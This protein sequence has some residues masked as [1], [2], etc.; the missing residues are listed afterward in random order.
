MNH[1][2]KIYSLAFNMPSLKKKTIK[3]KNRLTDYRYRRGRYGK[4]SRARYGCDF[5]IC[6]S[7]KAN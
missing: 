2:S 6:L 7:D 1:L 5:K 4:T 3:K